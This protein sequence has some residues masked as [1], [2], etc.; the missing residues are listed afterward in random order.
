MNDAELSAASYWL[1]PLPGSPRRTDHTK[2]RSSVNG[3]RRKLRS[4][5]MSERS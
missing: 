5:T 2:P 4:Q 1:V 3:S